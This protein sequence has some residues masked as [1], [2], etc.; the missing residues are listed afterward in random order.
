MIQHGVLEKDP[1]AGGLLLAML[2]CS[3]PF[4][5]QVAQYVLMHPLWEDIQHGR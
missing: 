1:V 5:E 3:T 2:C 4:E